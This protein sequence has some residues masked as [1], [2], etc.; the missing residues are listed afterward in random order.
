MTRNL[1]LTLIILVSLAIAEVALGQPA[2]KV[3]DPDI[4]ERYMGECAEGLAHGLGEA[5][6]RDNY[7][8]SFLKGQKHGTGDYRWANGQRYRGQYS[9]DR[10]NGQGRLEF[11]DG[12]AYEGGFVDG[13]MHGFG[14]YRW[15]DGRTYVGQHSSGSREGFA[16]MSV[17]RNSMQDFDRRAQGS[18]IDAHFVYVGFF[19]AGKF[20]FSCSSISDC[21]DELRR[22][23]STANS[24]VLKG[25]LGVLGAL[26]GLSPGVGSNSNPTVSHGGLRRT[27]QLE[28][29]GSVSVECNDSNRGL[30]ERSSSGRW[31]GSIHGETGKFACGD[32][33]LEAASQ[34]C[35]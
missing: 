31:C 4:S 24:Q 33:A 11:S 6:G 8:G 28:V 1:R 23:E 7:K 5:S 19:R 2:C 27:H 26:F 34:I 35:R 30:L 3:T 32:S 29:T 16:K 12:D 22:R 15:R 20:Q 17:P 13:V 9:N 18:I 10:R 21:V 14:I 25:S